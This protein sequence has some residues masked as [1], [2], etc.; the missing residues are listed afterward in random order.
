MLQGHDVSQA[1]IAPLMSTLLGRNMPANSVGVLPDVYAYMDGDKAPPGYLS[2][3][4]GNEMK[5]RA[6]VIN[7]KVRM[8][9]LELQSVA[10]LPWRR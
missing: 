2:S 5:A 10:D 4:G 6:S 9:R 1:D 7:A 3:Q 8:P